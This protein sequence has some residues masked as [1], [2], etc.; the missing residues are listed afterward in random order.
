[1]FGVCDGPELVTMFDEALL[2]E[3]VESGTCA[4]F[5]DISML[6]DLGLSERF[7]GVVEKEMV[8]FPLGCIWS[9]IGEFISILNGMELV[10]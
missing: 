1:M 4:P 9:E 8:D 5:W 2:L 7:V 10:F 3:P 6:D